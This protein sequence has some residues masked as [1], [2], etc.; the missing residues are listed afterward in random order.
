M[1]DLVEWVTHGIKRGR[2]DLG[3]RAM[4]YLA[5]LIVV[6]TLLAALYLRLV[7][8]TAAMGRRIEALRQELL[9][10]QQEN[11]ELEVEVAEASSAEAL[12]ERARMLGFKAAEQIEFLTVTSVP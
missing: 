9:I 7:S 5:V 12:L 3:R 8:Q 2:S 6:L 4:V 11:Q 10:L 1:S